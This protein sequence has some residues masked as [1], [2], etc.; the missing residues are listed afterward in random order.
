M[1][2]DTVNRCRA[3]YSVVQIGMRIRVLSRPEI[4]QEERG[5]S[6]ARLRL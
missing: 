2:L 1:D 4:V 3:V 6:R 5:L